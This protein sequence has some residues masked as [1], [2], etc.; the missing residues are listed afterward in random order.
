MTYGINLWIF[1]TEFPYWAQC[2][3]KLGEKGNTQTPN[4]HYSKTKLMEIKLNIC[5]LSDALE[6]VAN[7]LQYEKFY[8]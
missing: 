7:N 3:T 8:L 6:S 2:L 1:S 4:H 5:I